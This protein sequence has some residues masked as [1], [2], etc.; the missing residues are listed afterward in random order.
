ME[1]FVYVLV[2]DQGI[3]ITKER[4]SKLGEP[5]YSN[6]EKGSG[7][8]LM[9]SYKII[10]NHKGRIEFTSQLNMGTKVKILLPIEY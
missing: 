10:Q 8:G 5:F 2:G 9:I 3:G 1:Q 6:K 4:L 7:L